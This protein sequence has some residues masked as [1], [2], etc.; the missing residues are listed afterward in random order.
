MATK[1]QNV[2]QSYLGWLLLINIIIAGIGFA[3]I[4]TLNEPAGIIALLLALAVTTLNAIAAFAFAKGGIHAEMNTFM[5]KV[6]GGMGLRMLV[7]LIVVFLVIFLTELPIFVFII[8]LFISY[9]SKSVLEIIFILKIKDN[10]EL[11]HNG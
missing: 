11:I 10:P 1:Q 6:M 5:V 2:W 8:S 3:I 7:M 4:R 9:I